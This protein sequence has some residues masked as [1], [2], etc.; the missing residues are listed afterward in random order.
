MKLAKKIVSSLIFLFLLFFLTRS[1]VN[2]QAEL[3]FYKQTKNNYQQEKKR[4]ISLK[5]QILRAKEK[6]NLEK[7]IRNKLGFLKKDEVALIIPKITP[8]PTV[9]TPSPL[10][11]WQRWLKTFNL[12]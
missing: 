7:T 8:S 10:P 4:N 6:N 11:N 2:Y 9:I 3:V 12:N 1:F 5:T